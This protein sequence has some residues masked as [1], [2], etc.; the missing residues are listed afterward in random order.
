MN[1]LLKN[2]GI[3]LLLAF[4]LAGL[5]AYAQPGMDPEVRIKEMISSLEVTTEQEPKF[6]EAMNAYYGKV[7]DSMGGGG[8]DRAAMMAKIQELQAEQE[9]TLAGILNEGQMAKY[10]QQQAERRARMGQ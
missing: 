9:T 8:G 10:K 4:G 3:L 1:K 2:F 7:R 5:S 6:R